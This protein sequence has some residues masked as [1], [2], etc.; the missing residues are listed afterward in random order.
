M[1]FLKRL[2]GTK[3]SP[4][5][6]SSQANSPV[7][8]SVQPRPKAINQSHKKAKMTVPDDLTDQARSAWLLHLKDG[9]GDPHE[10]RIGGTPIMAANE[11]WPNC[12][13]CEH[14]LSFMMQCNLDESPDTTRRTG[15]G[16]LRLFYCEHE[17]CVGMGGWEHFAPQ[18][19]LSILRSDGAKRPVPDGTKTFS[20]R[21]LDQW[22]KVT[23]LPHQEDLPNTITPDR[24]RELIKTD[25]RPYPGHKLGGWPYWI[26]GAER[27]KCPTCDTTM[28]LLF[29]LDEDHSREFNFGGGVG[30]ITQC[31]DHPDS[32]AFGWA[33]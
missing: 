8:P 17:D 14:P 26:Q 31:P 16:I 9:D 3:Q 25:I 1:S 33:C 19:H 18:H 27:P 23:D 22:E 20:A 2:F 11:T 24:R 13:A 29:Q 10:T 5:P 4:M 15:G 6:F 32:L 28:P 12:R 21:Q 7:D 30:H